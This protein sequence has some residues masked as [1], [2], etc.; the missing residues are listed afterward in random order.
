MT[1]E[2]IIH[3]S[4]DDID[5]MVEWVNSQGWQH[6]VEWRWFKPDWFKK[7]MH[8]IF[9]F[10]RAEHANWFALRWGS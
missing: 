7:Q 5:E 6:I 2:V 10:E 3:M 1:Y 4:R 8:Y 9:Q